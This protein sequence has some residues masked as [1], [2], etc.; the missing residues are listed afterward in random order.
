MSQ[1]DVAEGPLLETLGEAIVFFTGDIVVS[2]VEQLDGAV[3]TAG[4]VEAGIHR[5]MFVDVFAIFDGC[6]LDFVD[7]VF[8]FVAVF[9]FLMARFAMVWT[10]EMSASIAQISKCVKIGRM[11]TL[12]GSGVGADSKE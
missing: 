11:C 10:I 12:G 9:L 2:L 4:P 3:E 8:D 6:L 7:G 5:R 1:I